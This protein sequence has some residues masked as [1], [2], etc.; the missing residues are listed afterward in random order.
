METTVT[1][2][3][4]YG[5]RR[6]FTSNHRAAENAERLAIQK[7]Y[8]RGRF[9]CVDHGLSQPGSST[10]YGQIGH[11]VNSQRNLISTDTGRVRIDIEHIPMSSSAPN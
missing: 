10:C 8:G 7:A 4:C 5:S 2:T 1:I 11:Y 9:L 3:E 6:T